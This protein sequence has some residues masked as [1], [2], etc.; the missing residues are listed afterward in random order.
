MIH[1]K[2]TKFQF[3]CS[4]IVLLVPVMPVGLFIV[5]GCFL[6]AVAELSGC[7]RLSGLQSLTCSLFNSLLKKFFGP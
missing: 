7:D 3:Q 6:A 1:K 5:Y 4:Q 2:Y